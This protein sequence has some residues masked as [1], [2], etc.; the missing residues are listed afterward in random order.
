MSL[1]WVLACLTLYF[2]N[3]VGCQMFDDLK[4]GLNLFIPTDRPGNFREG[5]LLIEICF[6][7]ID[8]FALDAQDISSRFLPGFNAWLVIGVNIDQTGIEPDGPFE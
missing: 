3:R 1:K 2:S 8:D 6:Q 4:N 5:E 7:V